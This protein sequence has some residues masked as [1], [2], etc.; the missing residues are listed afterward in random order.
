MARYL[1]LS[2]AARLVGI[3]RGALQKKIRAG[4]L[5]TFEGMLEL[6]ELLRVYPNV[7]VE[8]SAMMERMDRFI[9]NAWIKVAKSTAIL[10]DAE[11]LLTRVSLLSQELAAAKAEVN[12]YAELVDQL[13]PRIASL[14]SKDSETNEHGV[15]S[16]K[17]WFLHALEGRETES[18]LP[19]RLLAREAFLRI[20]AA[21]VRILPSGHEFFVEG[22]DN[23]LEAGLRSGVSLPY[24][25][26]D[27]SCGA[28]KVKLASGKVRQVRD[29]AYHLSDDEVRKGNILACC[30]AAVTDVVL[31]A[32]EARSSDDITGQTIKS[33][34]YK[35][36][37]HEDAIV[38]QAKLGNGERLRFLAGQYARIQLADG[39]EADCAIASCPCDERSLEF[40]LSEQANTEFW[41]YA[42]K[43]M[44]EGEEL[45]IRGPK[46]NFVMDPASTRPLLFVAIDTG[47]GAV[48]S[49]VEHAMALDAA[50]S[51]H[52]YRASS[53]SG[54]PYLDNLCRSWA[55]ALDGFAYT[56]LR[57]DAKDENLLA[58]VD[59]I[60]EEYPDLAQHDVYLCAHQ[61]Q[62]QRLGLELENR[63]GAT[64]QRVNIEPI[65]T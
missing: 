45:T 51:I 38:V 24:G 53:L 43:H 55:D 65:R 50:E 1:T 16:F 42:S 34:I 61:D 58:V 5:S 28:C 31:E 11:T 46:G 62:L 47:F 44:A 21:H 64:D 22:Q 2:R 59:K 8:D 37:R 57:L 29:A 15:R 60:A 30:C 32:D 54:T 4:E 9:E 17:S 12:R 40:H 41:R 39:S 6:N 49:L 10:P 20:M 63:T 52:L 13:K 3:K 56:S 14:D 19:E 23:L 48:K 26:N 27:A 33:Q 25:C 36:S 18:D 35:I 7:E